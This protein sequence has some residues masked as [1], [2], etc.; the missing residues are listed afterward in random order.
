MQVRHLCLSVFI[1]GSL[2]VGCGPKKPVANP[3][4]VGPT[5]SMNEVVEA[6]NLNN[7]RLPTLWA[8]MKRN[9]L[10]ASIVD[11]H[12]KR[13]DEVLGGTLLYRAPGEVK[14]VGHH[15]VAGDVVEIGSNKDVY[16]M[17]VREGPKTAWWG[18]YKY[19]GAQCSQPIPIRPELVLQVLG[20]STINQDFEA[21]PV[22]VM[23]FNNDSDCYMFIWNT[24]LPD[25]W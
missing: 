15:D 1:C 8:S 20:I 12:G 7:R 6:I 5:E 21:L 2:V 4:Y 3:P 23:R 24:K 9:G 22:P 10:E 18:R 19:L 11:D 16:W 13:D 14:V 17:L 25:R